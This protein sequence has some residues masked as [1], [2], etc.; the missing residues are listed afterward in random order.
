MKLI[1]IAGPAGSGKNAASDVLC[2]EH[3][4]AMVALADPIKRCVANLWDWAPEKL[5]G[6]SKFRNE[7]DLRYMRPD[8]EPLSP[9]HAL[10]VMGTQFGR[11]CD[12]D[13]WVRY[14]LR[15]AERLQRGDC[16]Y[17][18]T[19]GLRTCYGVG[20]M[21]RPKVNVVI[22]DVR[23]ANEIKAIRAAGGKVWRI[24]RNGAGLKGEAGQHASEQ[25]LKTIPSDRF[26]VVID[27]NGTLDELRAKVMGQ[28]N[29]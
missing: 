16:V 8:G 15:V 3:G 9:R 21:M 19:I 11:A 20:D 13:V 12:A 4:F 29:S 7:A 2:R 14:A 28:V 25:E 5:W 10:Q 22:P 1:G 18:P 6:E 23:F 26:D 17:D 24:V 27:N